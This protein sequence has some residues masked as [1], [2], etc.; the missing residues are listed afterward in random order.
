MR[1]SPSQW[2]ALI[3]L[4]DL[5]VSARK[6][7]SEVQLSYKTTLRAYDIIRESIV[8]HLALEDEILRGEI[9]HDESYFGGRRK[10]KRG[11][12]AAEKTIVFGILERG[13][14]VSVNI[15]KDVKADTLIVNGNVKIP[16][17]GKINFLTC[18]T[19]VSFR[20]IGSIMVT[21][22]EFLMI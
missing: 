9:E 7:S 17:C 19:S 11:R 21:Q 22:E 13:G 4:F 1:I 20:N 8:D 18:K 10:G 3:K 6:A 16:N 12:G 2:L 5:S 14:K 15:V